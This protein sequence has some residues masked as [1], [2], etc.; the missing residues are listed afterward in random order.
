MARALRIVAAAVLT[1]HGLVHLVGV[2]L[3]G[4]RA[5]PGELRHD[6]V[7][8]EAGSTAAVGVGVLWLVVDAVVPVCVAAAVASAHRGRRPAGQ[9]QRP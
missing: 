2:A 1:V 6:D 5:E 3:L 8:P 7:R 4:R 9:G